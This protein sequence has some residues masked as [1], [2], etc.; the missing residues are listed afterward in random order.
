MTKGVARSLPGL[1]A[2]YA[3]VTGR[4]FGH[5]FCPFLYRDE[6]AELCEGHVVPESFGASSVKVIQR[7]D[8]DNFFGSAFEGDFVGSK[9][10]GLRVNDV[11]ADPKL[12]RRFRP[13]LEVDGRSIDY[14]RPTGP[15]PSRHSKVI[16]D[17]PGGDFALAVKA[18]PDELRALTEGKWRI[19]MLKDLRV[20]ALVS[21]LKA[22]HLTLFSMLGYR[23]VLSAGGHLLGHDIL[24][25]FFHDYGGRPKAE[26]VAR[27]PSHFAEFGRIVATMLDVPD[28]FRGTVDESA[29]YLCERGSIRWGM[30]VMVRTLPGPILSV[31]V[32]L[33]EQ[34]IAAKMY[35]D[36]IRRPIR[37]EIVVRLA[38]FR[39]DRWECAKDTVLAQWP[40]AAPLDA[41]DA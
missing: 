5:F 21:S 6:A 9:Y 37:E 36:F 23:Y 4:P 19:T 2:D 13:K 35:L 15:I 3:E 29:V 25:K 32:P 12:S 8:V 39:G 31:L 22:A 38:W 7:K 28:T 33:S 10:G 20:P 40:R 16:L 27:A 30:I 26:T 34:S 17:G 18:P 1:R 14:Y 41:D 24:G 11:I